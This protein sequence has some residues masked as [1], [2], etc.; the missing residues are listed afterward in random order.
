MNNPK[1]TIKTNN[2]N[3]LYMIDHKFVYITSIHKSL[4]LKLP[5]N[6]SNHSHVPGHCLLVWLSHGNK[7]KVFDTGFRRLVSSTTI[8]KVSIQQLSFGELSCTLPCTCTCMSL[9]YYSKLY[10][11]QV[12]LYRVHGSW[13]NLMGHYTSAI[14]SFWY[15]IFHI[16]N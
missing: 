12:V 5:V 11:A 8:G 16:F 15:S 1:L 14:W 9:M 4:C 6:P 13:A 3:S 7:N 2:S 10:P